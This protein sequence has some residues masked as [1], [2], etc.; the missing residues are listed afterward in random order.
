MGLISQSQ[1][2]GRKR[3]VNRRAVRRLLDEREWLSGKMVGESCCLQI[4]SSARSGRAG[5]APPFHSPAFAAAS[6][7][8]AC[9]GNLV[10]ERDG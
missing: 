6:A 1:R 8:A 9:G 5:Q 7:A 2:H 4:A 3:G 10:K